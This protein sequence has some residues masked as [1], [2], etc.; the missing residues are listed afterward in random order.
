[1]HRP[2]DGKLPARVQYGRSAL[3][4]ADES[5]ARVAAW[6]LGPKGENRDFME[7]LLLRIVGV[8]SDFR[9]DHYNTHD[10]K[11]ITDAIK[12]MQPYKDAQARIHE[13]LGEMLDRLNSS[14]PFYS[15]HYLAHMN[16]DTL[17]PANIGY[18]AAMLFNQNNVATEASPETSK[19]ELDV[20]KDLCTLFG[21][22]VDGWDD[23]SN[24]AVSWGHVTAD[25]TIANLESMWVAR[26]IKSYPLSL[27]Q[28]LSKEADLAAGR[29]VQVEYKNVQRDFM[30]LSEW[31]LLNLKGDVILDLPAAIAALC[32]P[33]GRDSRQA[34]AGGFRQDRP[35]CA[36]QHGAPSVADHA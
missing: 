27:W 6:F 5:Y 10:P 3:P 31:E 21:F 17:L 28:M 1:M 32:W 19:M 20:A 18:F 25:G 36:G 34:G 24:S 11:Y 35:Q 30:T 7:A 14:V 33:T 23:G 16:W 29:A 22:D 15:M 9:R 2:H 8:H 26:N 13:R 4:L 12:A